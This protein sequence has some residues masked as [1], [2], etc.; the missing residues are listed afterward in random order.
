[1]GTGWVAGWA[2]PGTTPAPRKEVPVQRSGPRK[3]C[4]AWSGWYWGRVRV[5]SVRRRGR[6]LYHP[7]GPVGLLR[8]PPCTGPLECRLRANMARFRDISWKLSQNG[9][10]SPENVEKACHSPCSQNEVRNSPLEIL[11]FLFLSAFS[12]KELMVPF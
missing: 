4:R 9:R 12:H 5:L 2:I 6:L 11:R 7:P 1:M 8:S 10:V 3:A